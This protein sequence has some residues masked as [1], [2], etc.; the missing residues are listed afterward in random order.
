M[1]RGKEG[2]D[3][4]RRVFGVSTPTTGL[5]NIHELDDRSFSVGLNRQIAKEPLLLGA[6]HHHIVIALN[7]LQVS[8]DIAPTQRSMKRQRFRQ[9]LTQRLRVEGLGLVAVANQCGHA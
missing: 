3:F 7:R 9:A 1:R 4:G 5:A 8:A 6:S 2:S